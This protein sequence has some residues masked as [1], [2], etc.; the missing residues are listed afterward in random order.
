M[1]GRKYSMVVEGEVHAMNHGLHGFVAWCY[2]SVV[3]RELWIHANH[4][5]QDHGLH[6]V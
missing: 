5:V 6:V 2:R 1:H 4:M 3:N